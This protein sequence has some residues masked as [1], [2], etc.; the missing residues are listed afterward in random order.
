M[1]DNQKKI[2]IGI[3]IAI[4]C[5]A[6]FYFLYWTKTPVYSLGIIR[7]SIEKHDVDTFERHVDLDT[8]FDKGF[9]DAFVAK[10]RIEGK[11]FLEDPLVAGMVQMMKKPAVAA[12]KADT[13]EAVK[14]NSEEK[15]SGK[16]GKGDEFARN[17][18]KEAGVDQVVFKGAS[19]ISKEGNE[20]IVSVKFYNK[21]V[22]RAFEVKLKMAKLD[23]GTWKVKQVT[24][25]VDFLVEVDKAVE[26]KLA[27]L[28]KPIKEELNNAVKVSDEEMKLQSDG[29]PF[30]ASYWM[31]YGVKLANNSEKEI[32]AVY[33]LGSVVGD[34]GTVYRE[35]LLRYD[36]APLLA[37]TTV[38]V[39]YKD[40]LNQFLSA[41]KALI[42]HPG[43]K[44]L[45]IELVRIKYSDGSEVKILTQLPEPQKEKKK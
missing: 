40:E 25:L 27:E 10:D 13:L 34:D 23:D 28:N 9:D 36:K 5:A 21:Q 31:K 39:V 42:D 6:A 8:L 14:G 17:F 11:N 26:A 35:Q 38:N 22:D 45:K 7:E 30:F 41:D 33:M 37:H 44:K 32:T 43:G 3:V 4:L 20:A 2:G 19:V 15:K 16:K 24:N 18:K 12:L 1:N 29:N